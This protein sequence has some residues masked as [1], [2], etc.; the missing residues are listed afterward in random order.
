MV[1][2]GAVDILGTNVTYKPYLDQ[3]SNQV[4]ITIF[5]YSQNNL[6][7]EIFFNVMIF[8]LQIL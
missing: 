7:D 4:L 3:E 5:S 1:I 6:R 2:N 8:I